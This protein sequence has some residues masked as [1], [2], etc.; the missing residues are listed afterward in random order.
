MPERC[1][2]SPGRPPSGETMPQPS[3]EARASAVECAA[4][5]RELLAAGAVG[6]RYLDGFRARA[7]V[8]D[9]RVLLKVA[10]EGSWRCECQRDGCE[11]VE[12]VRLVAR[13]L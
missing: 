10:Y 3:S 1:T 9:G 5:A 2:F 7:I 13:V 4:R 8:R 11:H 6:L 12:A